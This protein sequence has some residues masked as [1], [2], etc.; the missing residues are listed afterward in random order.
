MRCGLWVVIH[1]LQS[2]HVLVEAVSGQR[3]GN[4][5]LPLH[6]RR[7]RFVVRCQ[8]QVTMVAHCCLFCAT[9]SLVEEETGGHR[10]T[11]VSAESAATTS[12]Y[13]VHAIPIQRQHHLVK[14]ASHG[15]AQEN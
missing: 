3:V 6:V 14:Q 11:L 13:A 15:C 12:V 4:T 1:H 8:E 7:M 9:M 2:P 5:L 10:V